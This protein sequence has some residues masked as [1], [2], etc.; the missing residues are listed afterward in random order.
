MSVCKGL[1]LDGGEA[2]AQRSGLAQWQQYPAW[3]RGPAH[4][5]ND[6]V[7]LDEGRAE[8][9]L[10]RGTEDLMFDLADLAADWNKRNTRDVLAFARRHGLLWHGERDLGTGTCREPLSEWWG[11]SRRMAFLMQLSAEL[12]ES[13]RIDSGR[14]IRKMIGDF[15]EMFGASAQEARMQWLALSDQELM[16]TASMLLAEAVTT[17]LEGTNMGL[18]SG[19][20]TSL[21]PNGPQIFLLSQ[22]P[23]NLL[24]AA[25]VQFAQTVVSRAP[26]EECPG[27]RRR[28]IPR[29]G[30]QKYCTNR[31]AS[32][33]RWRRWNERQ[34]NG[35]EESTASPL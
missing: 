20:H 12:N 14:P 16:H 10:M 17:K 22:N 2:V 13:V 30:K 18:V 9:Y 32:T 33:S 31:C 7:V 21:R 29:S 3:V 1:I 27:C 35:P 15:P 34:A 8:P 23:P 24:A 26:I 19:A 28:F 25:Y 4:M 11:E 6:E 5:V